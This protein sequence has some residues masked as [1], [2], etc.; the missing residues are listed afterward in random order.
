[1]TALGWL[2]VVALL[3]ALWLG[4]RRYERLDAERARTRAGRR[5]RLLDE[6]DRIY[7]QDADG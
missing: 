5:R 4:I 3:V 6:L 1:M 2:A 7:D